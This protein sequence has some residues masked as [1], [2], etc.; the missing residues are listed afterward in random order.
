MKTETILTCPACDSLLEL[1]GQTCRCAKGHSFDRSK[2][3]YINL[4]LSHQRRSSHPGDDAKMIQARRRFF[5]S[6]AFDP[7]TNFILHSSCIAQHSSLSIL[8]CGCGEGHFLGALSGTRFG[9]DISKEAIRCAAK[10]YKDVNWIVANGMRK[11]PFADQSLDVILSV[12]APRNPEEFSRILKPDG[13]LI[14]GVPGPNHLIELR[15]QLATHA[16]DFEEKADEAAVKCAPHFSE[17]HREIL[18]Y[19]QTLNAAQIA[20]LVQMTPIFWNSSSEAKA[21]VQELNELNITVSFVLLT[22]Q[23]SDRAPPDL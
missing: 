4:L 7:L 18:S 20:D 15:S 6:G 2:E 11:L 9:M 13:A 12:L 17:I 21:R 19:Q 23:R 8:D 16:G 5:D 1:S 14:L 3:G 10:R 22:L